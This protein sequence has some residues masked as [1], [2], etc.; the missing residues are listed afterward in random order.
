MLY[1]SDETIDRWIKEDVPYIDLTTLTMGIAYKKGRIRFRAR[2]YTILAGVEEVL[3]I[4]AKLGILLHYSIATGTQVNEGEVFLEAEGTASNLHMAR[5]VS[6][7]LL[8]Y[9]SG[10]ATRTKIL[11]DKAKAVKADISVLT[12][13]K[14]F[15]GT[16][17]LAIKS[18]LAGG[19]LPHRLGLSETGLIFK[20]HYNFL[21][22]IKNLIPAIMQIKANT[23]EKKIIVEVENEEDALLLAS[24]EVDGLQ[25]DKISPQNL[26]E[27]VQKIKRVNPKITLLAA[28]GIN[29]TN[30]CEYACTDVDAIVTTS[31]YFGKPSNIGVEIDISE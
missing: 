4:F 25:F 15:P 31:I 30:I 21:N 20:N 26:K 12:T 24:T 18:I 14:S 13:R 6:Q 7:N 22:G 16:K 29:N 19:A 2:E 10:I 5:K 17:E 28:G 3:R 1:I 9:C 23:C 11:V 27:T 8:E